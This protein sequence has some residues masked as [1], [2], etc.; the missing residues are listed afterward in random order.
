[1]ARYR[2]EVDGDI[3]VGDGLCRE[4][5]PAT[6]G[7]AADGR[8][9][10]TDPDGDEPEDVLAAARDC[11][12][13]AIRLQDASTGAQIWPPET[14]AVAGA[15]QT[16]SWPRHFRIEVDAGTCVGDRY[17]CELAP[18]TFA[19]DREGHVMVVAADGDPPEDVLA[20]AK[21][22]RMEAIHLWDGDTGEEVWPRD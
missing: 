9:R 21:A 12:F 13:E 20:A 4:R 3:C 7:R 10:V 8:S 17:C 15:G 16:A 5:A 19:P 18:R 14:D 22:C 2:I 6:F 11:P 1:M